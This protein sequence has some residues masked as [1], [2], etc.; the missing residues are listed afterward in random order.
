MKRRIAQ[1]NHKQTP[2]PNLAP[3]PDAPAIPLDDSLAYR[4][5][6]Q[7]QLGFQRNLKY[8]RFSPNT[9]SI[10]S[11]NPIQN[12][13]NRLAISPAITSLLSFVTVIRSNSA[14]IRSARGCPDRW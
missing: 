13:S 8:S 4:T 3:N 1:H 6:P 10:G 7:V 11:A 12:G 2:I 9:N 5:D 14:L